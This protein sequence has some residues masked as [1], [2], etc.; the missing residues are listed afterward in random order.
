MISG[1]KMFESIKQ[2]DDN[3]KEYW[4]ARGLQTVLGYKE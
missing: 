2:I 3:G 4:S 1:E